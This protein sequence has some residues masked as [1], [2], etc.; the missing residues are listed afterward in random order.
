[1][2]ARLTACEVNNT[3]KEDAL[4]ASTPPG[5]AK[6]TLV[7]H[8]CKSAQQDSGQREQGAY[9]IEFYQHNKGLL[10]RGPIQTYLHVASALAGTPEAIRR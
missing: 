3:G 10:Q 4:Y 2:Q 6:K 1:M 8:V 9:E 5:E 7:L